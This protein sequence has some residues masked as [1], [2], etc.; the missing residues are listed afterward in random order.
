M[1]KRKNKASGHRRIDPKPTVAAP[2]TTGRARPGLWLALAGAAVLLLLGGVIWLLNRPTPPAT[3]S[4]IASP[5]V[6]GT[7]RVA[8]GTTR[9]QRNPEFVRTFGFD[10][11]RAALSTNERR[12]Q[13]L[14]L[15]EVGPNGDTSQKGRHFQAPSWRDAGHLG[16]ITRDGKGNLFAA[17]VPVISVL[18]NHPERQN[19]LWRAESV[20]GVLT[21]FV[22]LPP[23]APWDQNNPYGILGLT[24]DCDTNSLYV[25]SVYGSNRDRQV[26]RIFQ[27]D[28]DSGVV[29]STLDGIDAIGLGVYNTPGG[30]RL[31]FGSARKPEVMRVALDDSGRF[32]GEAT[33]ALSLEDL[34]PRGD[35]KA[36]RI[37]F[38]Q[39]ND[40][41][42]NG[43]EFGFNL[44]APTEKQETIYRF[45]Y[46]PASDTWVLTD[47]QR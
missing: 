18:D 35:D 38:L 4:A 45:R 29:R 44:I 10:P 15:L 28:A 40:M 39:N 41:Q 26:G 30:K 19:D 17:P 36:R 1:S 43:V 25:S 5:Q 37:S 23:G 6:A 33:R 47:S 11:Q 9:C 13:G 16:P 34:G 42:I 21:R 31:Y 14:V 8:G 22:S 3:S 27:I 20:T 32:L 46:D 7:P 12:Y 24:L 2:V